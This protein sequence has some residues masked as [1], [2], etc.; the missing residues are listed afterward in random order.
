MAFLAPTDELAP[1]V[2]RFNVYRE[3]DTSFTRRTEPPNGLA[4]L[5]FNLG[6]ELRVEHPAKTLHAYGAGGAFYTGVSSVYAV[7]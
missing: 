3:S 7:T 1:F 6:E 4:T 5:V 2:A